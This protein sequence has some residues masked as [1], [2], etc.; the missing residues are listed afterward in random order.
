M[1]SHL[2]YISLQGSILALILCCFLLIFGR[3][4][5]AQIR[6]WLIAV[7]LLRFLLPFTPPS[8]FSLFGLF[9]FVTV[10]ETQE[11]AE[12]PFPAV[13]GFGDFNNSPQEPLIAASGTN[14]EKLSRTAIAVNRQQ[15]LRLPI[16]VI[17]WGVGAVF[18]AIPFLLGEIQLIRRRKHWQ[19]IK[20]PEMLRLIA[21][22][23]QQAG[24][25]FPARVLITSQPV[26][27]ASCG[28]FRPII[29]LS[30]EILETFDREELRRILLHE[31]L[32][33]KRFDPLTHCLAQIV[34]ILHWFNPVV[35]LLVMK[36]RSEREFAVDE[37]VLRLSG[38]QSAPLYGNSILKVF[39]R[40]GTVENRVKSPTILGLQC[41]DKF[42]ER[43][44]TMILK[45]SSS[46][47]FQ[48]I[49]GTLLIFGLV[50]TGLTDAQTV[51]KNNSTENN[52]EIKEKI[53]TENSAGDEK[54]FVSINFRFVD[55]DGRILEK[56]DF[57]TFNFSYDTKLSNE[58]IHTVDHGVVKLRCRRS[59]LDEPSNKSSKLD[60]F[61][62]SEDW[63]L[64]AWESY[65]PKTWGSPDPETNTID[66]TITLYPG[67]R[68]IT[69]TVKDSGGKPVEGTYVGGGEDGQLPTFMK[70]KADGSFR[71]PYIGRRL[72]QVYAIK[73]E[74]GFTCRKTEELLDWEGQTPPD[75]ISD[76]PFHLVL[77]KPQTVQV[78]VTDDRGTPIPNAFVIPY[79]FFNSINSENI[80]KI[81]YFYPINT[82]P[83]VFF[84][85]TDETGTATFD[86][87]PTTDLERMMFT[88]KGPKE[89]VTLPDGTAKYFGESHYVTW[90]PKEK[91]VIATLPQQAKVKIKFVNTDGSPAYNVAS[92]LDWLSKTRPI[93]G[94]G[95]YP[96]TKGEIEIQANIGDVF[97][98][99]AVGFTEEQFIFPTVGHFIVGGGDVAKELTVTV[100][101]G[102]KI[103]GSIFDNDGKAI[104]S[105]QDFITVKVFDN[106]FDSNGKEVKLDR[107]FINFYES[108]PNVVN[109][110][111]RTRIGINSKDNETGYE[112]YLPPGTFTFELGRLSNEQDK[113]MEEQ[114]LDKKTIT[115]GDTPI[116]LD[117]KLQK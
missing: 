45:S 8:S 18:A 43:R 80:R 11:A 110:Y 88:V 114:L 73:P 115:V 72:L 17:I 81:D 5:S 61:V 9:R 2:L 78:R 67:V 98:L 42:L 48:K 59:I 51:Q 101:K 70:S 7:V 4:L 52:A 47:L 36:F 16:T 14:S 12:E 64:A 92:F 63:T 25:W 83:P 102:T 66:K 13:H 46:T 94:E 71:F 69:G 28:I 38:Y 62:L 30:Q 32:H 74:V 96:N 44:I 109:K 77:D 79:L 53:K 34:K 111:R 112:V 104:K 82:A 22:C 37:A 27:A 20:S 97:N 26:G 49:F 58:L 84:S 93:S 50:F 89:V 85:K 100:R 15:H 33:H 91:I 23:R 55:Q 56:T 113:K 68:I 108:N 103:F 105:G 75:K 60:I 10:A 117:W 76:G 24:L 29:L 35:W 41:Q 86:W 54:E 39:R 106:H 107:Y 87:I 19:Y 31:L 116:R 57:Y 40:Y 99:R 1:F 65:D 90:N 6:F 95:V 21:E 3:R